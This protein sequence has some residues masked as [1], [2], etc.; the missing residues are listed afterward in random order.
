MAVQSAGPSVVVVGAG[1]NGLVAA[2]YLRRAGYAVTVLE[3]ADRAGGA[4]VSAT[5]TVD[6]L[7]QSYAL[8]A[9]VLGLMPDFIFRET[10]LAD[11]L[12]TYVPSSAKRVYFPTAGASAW[13]YR[14]PPGSTRNSARS[15]ASSGDAAGFRADEA[16]VVAF[17]QEGYR[18]PRR[19]CRRCPRRTRR[20]ADPPVDHRERR[21]SAGPLLHRRANQDLPGDDRHRERPRLAREP[22]SAFTLPLMDSG[23]VFGGYYGFVKRRDSGGSPRSWRRST[24]RSASNSSSAPGSNV[25]PE[26]GSARYSVTASDGN[27]PFD[28]LV[29]ATDPPAA[30]RL[31]GRR[32]AHADRRA[33]SASSA[34]AASSPCSSGRFAVEGWADARTRHAVPIHLRRRDPGRFRAGDAA[35]P[36]GDVDYEPGYIQVYCEGAAM[37]QLGLAEPFDRLTLFFKNLA[38]GRQG[39][40]A[41]GRARHVNAQL[42][43]HVA[44]PRTASG[45]GC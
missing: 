8:G 34:R 28:H 4:C 42:L 22:S 24:A 11:R 21:R 39:D 26:R 44:T 16:R 31:V 14:D 35:R 6:G 29:F 9:S 43:A 2:H 33:A 30:A 13:I 36:T 12:D 27:S 40:A 5:A 25:D 45:A 7:T 37:R 20:R 17:L 15:G 41:P 10:G 3:R 18:A 32:G 38:L 1:I 19:R 23:S